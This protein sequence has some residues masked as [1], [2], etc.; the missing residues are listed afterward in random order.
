VNERWVC[1]RCFAD[2]DDASAACHRCG[3]T[4]GAEASQ[5]D[6]Q[7][8]A[9]RGGPPVARQPAGAGWTRWIRFWWIPAVVIV[10]A[11][12]YVTQAR[13]D[14]G[15]GITDGGTLQVEDLRVGDCF[16][17]EDAEEISEVDAGP[18]T[19]P[20]AYEMFHLATWSGA[21][22]F[23]TDD[24]MV[25]FILQACIPVFEDYV[26]MDYE[27]SAIDF[28][29]FTPTEE[30]WNDGDRLIQC[31]LVDPGNDQLTASLRNANR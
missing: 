6:Q 17:A 12:G 2:N 8:W 10:L 21:D 23:P 30:G 24:A 3:L 29:P 14:N 19:D 5:V 11:V 31:A 16:D 7:G 1:K 9:E 20:H 18:C 22:A 25:D 26:G 28:V 15:G 13:R 4:R 27:S